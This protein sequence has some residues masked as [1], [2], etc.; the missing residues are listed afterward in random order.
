MKNLYLALAAIGFALPNFF[1]LRESLDTGNI[2]LYADPVATFSTMFA[3]NIVSAFSI[4]LFIVV[5]IFFIW[6]YRIAKQEN[7]P[8]VWV[9]WLLTMAFGL[10]LGFPLFLYM[11]ER[12]RSAA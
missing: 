12:K 1:V 7:M 5:F 10:A 6:S 9:Y 3:N 4:D 8:K 2:L 11:R